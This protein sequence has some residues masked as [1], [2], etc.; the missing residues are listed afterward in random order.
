MEI[1]IIH[2]RIATACDPKHAMQYAFHSTSSFYLFI[3]LFNQ[4][5]KVISYQPPVNFPLVIVINAG[6]I[7]CCRISL[8]IV[9]L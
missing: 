5:R 1:F 7:E 4:C 2:G 9:I 6:F 8:A 3:Y